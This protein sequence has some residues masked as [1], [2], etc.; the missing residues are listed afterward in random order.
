MT[1][2]ARYVVQ[3]PREGLVIAKPLQGGYWIRQPLQSATYWQDTL[4]RPVSAPRRVV[5]HTPQVHQRMENDEYRPVVYEVPRPVYDE[6]RRGKWRL[7]SR[8]RQVSAGEYLPRS[9]STRSL[10]HREY[11]VTPRGREQRV[12]H[13]HQGMPRYYTRHDHNDARH[14]DHYDE[15]H[16][17]PFTIRT[18]SLHE[19]RYYD[20]PPVREPRRYAYDHD[21][22]EERRYYSYDG[23]DGRYY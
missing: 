21:D 3:Q 15:P 19:P 11:A 6:P 14:Y 17:Q 20:G 12:Y 16:R 2:V 13:Q 5:Y 22:W 7:N 23:D 18:T 4:Y 10:R 8:G 9:A 1:E